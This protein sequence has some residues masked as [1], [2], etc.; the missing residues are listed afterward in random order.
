MWDGSREKINQ[1]GKFDASTVRPICL[2]PPCRCWEF[3]LLACWC[4]ASDTSAKMSP[5][6]CPPRLWKQQQQHQL[7]HG[8]SVLWE[9]AKGPFLCRPSLP[10]PHLLLFPPWHRW[11]RGWIS[12]KGGWR[13]M[14]EIQK[15]FTKQ[16][17]WKGI[18]V[19][20]APQTSLL[21]P[22]FLFA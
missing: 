3:N 11:S 19:I 12:C 6:S 10:V 13:G 9:H 8:A 22:L 14:R 1:D 20:K 17:N 5:N 2:N 16:E 7:S 4:S 21:H 18:S 15:H